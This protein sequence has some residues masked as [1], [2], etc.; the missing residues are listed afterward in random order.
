MFEHHKRR[1]KPDRRG[2]VVKLVALLAA[3]AVPIAL[4]LAAAG[5]SLS[6]AARDP[7]GSHWLARALT[8]RLFVR[9]AII[10]VVAALLTAVVGA[11]MWAAAAPARARRRPQGG[12]AIVEFALGM[13]ILLMLSLIMAQASLL[14]GGNLCVNYAAFC[15]AR[16]AVVTV[17]G[18]AAP[19]EYPNM[20]GDPSASGK[21]SRIKAAAVWAVFPV[22]YSN[23]PE[24]EGIVDTDT[25]ETGMDRFFEQYDRSTPL[26]VRRHFSPKMAYAR[27][28]T[29]VELADPNI[30]PPPQYTYNGELYDGYGQ[31]E[32]LKVRVTHTFFLSV[33]Y[34]G[35]LLT[36][37]DPDGV[38]MDFADG[39]YG[40]V[41][42]ATCWLTNEGLRDSID[43]E[44]FY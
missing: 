13:P 31:N 28:Y 1:E 37:L 16:S 15:A 25:L 8:G 6:A 20:V 38:E 30:I 17:P 33:P 11:A 3:V 12:A 40:M 23:Y 29:E 44:D 10:L 36:Q 4:L 32:D 42:R 27:R 18:F 43:I 39:E 35:W 14:M 5:P 21:L 26:W 9:C 34:A 22:S 41:I 2:A 7:A 19:D 24:E